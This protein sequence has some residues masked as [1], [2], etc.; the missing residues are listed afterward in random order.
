MNKRS[1]SLWGFVGTV[2]LTIMMSGAQELGL[3][4]INFPFMLG[5][6]F[7]PDRD[8]AKLVGF[9]VHFVNGWLFA[10]IYWVH[11]P[12]LR[13]AHADIGHSVSPSLWGNYRGLLSAGVTVVRTRPSVLADACY[14]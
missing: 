5:T 8:R 6:A 2:I 12:Q 3:S 14:S 9:G 11:G 4:R 7:T 10:C 13:P 1:I